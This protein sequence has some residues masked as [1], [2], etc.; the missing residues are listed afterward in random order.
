MRGVAKEVP[1]FI[2]TYGPADEDQLR[3]KPVDL[4]ELVLQLLEAKG[5]L[6]VVLQEELIIFPGE[7]SQDA[8]G[9]SYLRRFGTSSGWRPWARRPA[10]SSIKGHRISL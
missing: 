9:S 5:Y 2:Q 10:G 1:I 6:D 4:F 3:V 7:Y 8:D